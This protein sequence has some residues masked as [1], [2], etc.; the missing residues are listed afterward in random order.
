MAVVR[1]GKD[2]Q[3]QSQVFSYQYDALGRRIAEKDSFGTTV[4]T[5]E[6][7]RLLEAPR[8]AP[9]ALY[10]TWSSTV[11]E[12]WQGQTRQLVRNRNQRAIRVRHSRACVCRGSTWAGG[13]GCTFRYYDAVTGA[14]ATS[15]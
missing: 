15:P 3:A 10:T 11:S 1:A 8:P 14:F 5:W 2:G 13:W 9:T 12:R 7:M 4:F 6:G